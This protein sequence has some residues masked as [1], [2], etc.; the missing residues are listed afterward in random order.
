MGITFSFLFEQQI[1]SHF[2]KVKKILTK[3]FRY[4][5][6][7]VTNIL[8]KVLIVIITFQGSGKLLWQKFQLQTW[9]DDF[10]QIMIGSH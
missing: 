9:L 6:N 7:A 8:T 2:T 5:L 3:G 1:G 10:W 4:I